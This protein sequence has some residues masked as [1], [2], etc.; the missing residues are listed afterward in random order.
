MWLAENLRTFGIPP[1][2]AYL[3]SAYPPSSRYLWVVRGGQS[4]QHHHYRQA[5]AA[6]SLVPASLHRGRGIDPYSQ[7]EFHTS[8]CPPYVQYGCLLCDPMP[9]RRM[10]RPSRTTA[11]TLGR[12]QVRS[13]LSTSVTH[14]T[15]QTVP[16]HCLL[17]GLSLPASRQV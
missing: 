7:A 4:P 6:L 8:V 14:P 13:P 5:T 17:T 9:S 15:G 10:R 12:L 11:V 3:L 1:S 2:Y 16:D